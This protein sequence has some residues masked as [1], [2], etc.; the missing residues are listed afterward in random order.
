MTKWHWTNWSSALKVEEMEIALTLKVF[1]LSLGCS[2]HHRQSSVKR[3]KTTSA[4]NII[5]SS[6]TENIIR[7]VRVKNNCWP[8]KNRN[9][10][11]LYVI[12][13][14]FF[15][16]RFVSHFPK[17]KN[18]FRRPMDITSQTIRVC[19]HSIFQHNIS[20]FPI[21]RNGAMDFNFIYFHCIFSATVE[22]S[23]IRSVVYRFSSWLH[24]SLCHS[25]SAKC[26]MN[27]VYL[28]FYFCD[29]YNSEHTKWSRF[30][31][32]TNIYDPLGTLFR[33][34]FHPIHFQFCLMT[35]IS[36]VHYT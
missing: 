32:G 31:T 36:G 7:L 12:A 9:V 15:S 16:L 19:S 18:S 29:I 8:G 14:Y 4:V 5:T 1:C 20:I 10:W 21:I 33:L 2:Q 3:K 22:H 27:A 25:P 35:L 6:R 17:F 28:N 24:F 26:D 30:P 23:N 11:H 13:N 34:S